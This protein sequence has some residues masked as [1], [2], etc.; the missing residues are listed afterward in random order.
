MDPKDREPMAQYSQSSPT[1]GAGNARDRAI[2]VSTR[3][4]NVRLNTTHLDTGACK[5][6]ISKER[7]APGCRL[8][9]FETRTGFDTFGLVENHGLV[10][11]S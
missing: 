8:R 11:V 5:P 4:K 6:S 2:A 7:S 3:S 10:L 9:G 1:G